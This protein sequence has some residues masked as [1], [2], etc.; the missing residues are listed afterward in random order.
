MRTNAGALLDKDGGTTVDRAP[1]GCDTQLHRHAV[2]PFGTS[3]RSCAES[4]LWLLIK[5]GFGSGIQCFTGM[6]GK[7]PF[8]VLGQVTSAFHMWQGRSVKPA[9]LPTS[10]PGETVQ[11]RANQRKSAAGSIS[12]KSREAA[13]SG[14][15]DKLDPVS[16][17]NATAMIGA[18]GEA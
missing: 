2:F 8:T 1:S 14:A 17:V 12:V 7:A 9:A 11:C 13:P 10:E 16:E 18:S 4:T 6:Q 15:D 5:A 3:Q